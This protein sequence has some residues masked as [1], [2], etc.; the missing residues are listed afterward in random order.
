MA[1]ILPPKRQPARSADFAEQEREARPGDLRPRQIMPFHRLELHRRRRA[2][3]LLQ[4]IA[5]DIE[6][7]PTSAPPHSS[8]T[9]PRSMNTMS[10][11]P[12]VRRGR[13]IARVA[14]AC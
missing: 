8:N 7:R 2:R 6:L 1:A 12:M 4:R 11:S 5:A 14:G 3:R 10:S 9:G 13:I